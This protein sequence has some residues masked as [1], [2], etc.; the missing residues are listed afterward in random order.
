MAEESIRAYGGKDFVL[1]RPPMSG[2][3]AKDPIDMLAKIMTQLQGN[4]EVLQ[5]IVTGPGAGKFLSLLP[6]RLATFMRNMPE[7]LRVLDVN[8]KLQNAGQFSPQGPIKV[9][10]PTL[11]RLGT[12]SWSEPTSDVA[13]HEALHALAY[14][15]NQLPLDASETRKINASYLPLPASKKIVGPALEK[16]PSL[17]DFMQFYLQSKPTPYPLGQTVQETA[18]EAMT[19]NILNRQQPNLQIW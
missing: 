17:N 11:P 15:K 4:P 2:E 8:P 13:T 18:I 5:S 16:D 14:R 10:S 7:E 1:D 3:P 9:G 12:V 19:R 6:P